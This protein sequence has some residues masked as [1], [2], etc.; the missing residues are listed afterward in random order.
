MQLQE[1]H[2]IFKI[3]P[4]I[5][6]LMFSVPVL[7]PWQTAQTQ[8]RHRRTVIKYIR[9]LSVHIIF[10]EVCY[11]RL[12]TRLITYG[13]SQMQCALDVSVIS[14]KPEVHPKICQW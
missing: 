4:Y 5:N 3:A 9:S 12:P 2:D 1:L 7:G 14:G 8:I 13:S 10:R 6:T 11:V